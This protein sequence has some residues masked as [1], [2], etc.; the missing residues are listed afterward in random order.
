MVPA[1]LIVVAPLG[2]PT[3]LLLET[4]LLEIVRPDF[5]SITLPE[6][7]IMRV[8]EL[9]VVLLP[10]VELLELVA[11]L[12]IEVIDERLLWFDLPTVLL[13]E[14]LILDRPTLDLPLSTVL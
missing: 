10:T 4:L 5:G 6:L 13:D 9:D 8:L 7:S 12:L 2:L 1:L 11:L 3:S 14:L